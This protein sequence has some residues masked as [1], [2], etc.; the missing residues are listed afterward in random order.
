MIKPPTPKPWDLQR[1]DKGRPVVLYTHEQL[2]AFGARER[3]AERERCAKL[4]EDMSA[5]TGGHGNPPS[6]SGHD[7]ACAIRRG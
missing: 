3:A 7:L 1:D 6:P 5:Y 4:C 2:L